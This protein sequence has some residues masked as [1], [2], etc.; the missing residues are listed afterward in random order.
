MSSMFYN[1]SSLISLNLSNF[2]TSLVNNMSSMFYN[3]SLLSYLDLSSFNTSRVSN[4]YSMFGKCKILKYLNT[5][6]F[7]TSQVKNMN[8]MFY[9]CSNIR[10]LDLSIFDTSQVKKMDRMFYG[11]SNINSLDLSNFNTSQ[12]KIMSYMF[13]GCPNINSLDLSNFDTSNVSNMAYMFF[14]CKFNLSN[15]FN[16]NTSNVKNMDGMF[17]YSNFSSLDLSNFDTSQVT[18]MSHMFRRSTV[19]SLNL[20][21]FNTSGVL[22]MEYMFSQCS[23]LVSLDLT[24]FDTSQ[25]IYMSSI[26][27]K[28]SNLRNLNI[29]NINT[30]KVIDMSSMFSGCSLLNSLDLLNFDT[31]Q[32]KNMSYMFNNCTSLY[33]LIISNFNT[34]NA[35][36]MNNMFA[37]C[38]ALSSLNL[39]NFDTSQV[40]NMSSMFYNC[41]NLIFLN[42]SSFDTSNVNDMNHMFYNCSLINSLELPNFNIKNVKNFNHMFDSCINLDYIYLNTISYINSNSTANY[43][44]S[45]TPDNL[46]VCYDDNDYKFLNIL[47]ESK[48]YKCHNFY[49][50]IKYIC[51]MKNSSLFNI[52]ICDRCKKNEI[53]FYNKSNDVYTNDKC[54]ESEDDFN[55][56]I[57]NDTDIISYDSELSLQNEN[58]QYSINNSSEFILDFVSNTIIQMKKQNEIMQNIIGNLLKEFD[59]R[60]ID[61][62]KD[63]K[64][65]EQNKAIILTSTLNQKNNEEENYIS[66][67][68]GECE[69]ILKSYY[70]ISKNDS[71]YILQVISEEEFMKIPK[72]EYEVY[73]PLYNKKNLTKLNL[74]LCK[75]T[76][77]AISISVKINDSLDKYDPKSDYYNDICS[78]ASSDSGTDIS[79]KDRKNEYVNNN[80][81]LCEENCELLEYNPK[82]EKAKCS[83]DIK[84][85]IPSD[86]DIKFNKNDFFKSFTDIEN[87]F[88]INIMKCYRIVLKIKSLTENYGFFIVDS[89][90]ILYFIT[91]F[92]FITFSVS[93]IKKEIYDI[94]LSLKINGNPIKK[95]LIKKVKKK[96]KKKKINKFKKQNDIKIYNNKK[97]K[98]NLNEKNKEKIENYKEKFSIDIEH[99]FNKIN[100]EQYSIIDKSKQINYVIMMK[101]DFEL[102]SLDY[103]EAFK[104]DHRNYF[105]YYFSLLKNSHPIIFSFGCEND[106]NSK[107]IKIFLFFFSLCLDLAVNALFFNDDTMHKIYED[108]GK[109]NFL[110]QIPQILYS[111]LISRFIDSI[112]RNFALIKDNV[113]ELKKEKDKKDL[114]IKYKKFLRILKIKFILFFILAFIF[115]IL[116][117]Y[118][119]TCFCGIYVNTQMHL[120]KDSLISLIISLLIPFGFC[121]IPAIFRISSLRVENPTRK[122]L[123]KLS[124]IIES[125]FC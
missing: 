80:M 48:K 81:S 64:I 91:L 47:P 44:F 7:N 51:Y 94:I 120:I 108:K 36:D 99:S 33:S 92:I 84:L 103:E 69:N 83:C 26:F 4:M 25:V 76:K 85:N 75:K 32:V 35:K 124:I 82:K 37:N 49:P 113:V 59:M 95:I 28:C 122:V 22:N 67:D 62:G 123:Y 5:S 24:N 21:N 112:I 97:D 115:I 121:L 111:T 13:Y 11:C 31:S 15:L 116:L 90:I 79:L 16:F 14:K 46:I 93:K 8:S 50:E 42:L 43:I 1:C 23:S 60:E 27:N 104:L 114:A 20:S 125:W 29:S 6:N 118:Y 71:L 70:N 96:K 10:S 77:I 19:S 88:N 63:K 110:Y 56:Y 107:I 117:A 98:M 3:C 30:S 61:N 66:M 38:K 34:S 2:N 74:S 65:I 119:I 55:S 106:Y 53:I 87:I 41:I 109:F 9:G 73:Y 105:Q 68:L 102:N 101:R 39:F 45:L 54:Y 17:S 86:Y 57:Y 58:Y 52:H 40:N 18:T 72:V 100:S 12:V 78:K 89:V